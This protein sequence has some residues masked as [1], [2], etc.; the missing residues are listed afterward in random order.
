MGMIDWLR[1]AEEHEDRLEPES[2][3]L[4]GRVIAALRTV[5]DPEIP[6]NIYDLGLVYQLSADEASGKVGIRMTLT[7]PGCP[8]AQAFPSVVQDAVMEAGGVNEVEV[9]LVWEPPWSRERMSEAARLE[10]GLI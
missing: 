9:E 10:L 8:V 7:A 3:S 5:Y 1:K 2:D 4:E 6:V